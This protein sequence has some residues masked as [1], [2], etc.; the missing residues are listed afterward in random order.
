MVLSQTY[1]AYLIH[2]GAVLYLICFLFRN[3]IHLRIFAMLGDVVYTAYYFGVTGHPLWE[4]MIWS[5]LNMTVNAVMIGVL[6]NDK[7]ETKLGDNELK[8][9]RNLT[10]LSPG[11]FRKLVGLGKWSVASQTETLTHEGQ[12]LDKLFYVLEGG[13][14]IIKSGR[15]IQVNPGLF[16]GE[17]GYLLR[18]PATATVSVKPGTIYIAWP[19]VELSKAFEKHESLKHALGALLSS[20]LAE[21]VA[22]T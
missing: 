19:H 17:I 1:Y 6:L 11:E 5:T 20:D 22:R 12:I 9:Y 3:Q 21:K 4:A 13:L 8:L 18:K 7:R 10:S 14:D 15:A 2:L 16:I